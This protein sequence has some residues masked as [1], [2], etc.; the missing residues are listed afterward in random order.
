MKKLTKKEQRATKAR[1]ESIATK[2]RLKAGYKNYLKRFYK[3]VESMD[4]RNIAVADR[5]A[6]SF[7]MYKVARE[8][9]AVTYG[10]TQN[11]NQTIVADQVYQY[12]YVVAQNLKKY[13]KKYNKGW[14]E[15]R[16]SDI[17][18]A[19][20]GDLNDLLTDINTD[21]K[22]QGLTGTQRAKW[23]AQEVFGSE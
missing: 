12:D 4:R 16:V 15:M 18:E 1:Y 14:A 23:I 20:F 21:L 22:K 11:I 10:K 19:G 17:R 6:M 9:M 3:K 8:N 13:A 5:T 2:K 7:K